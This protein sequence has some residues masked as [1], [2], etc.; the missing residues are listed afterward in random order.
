M[1]IQEGIVNRLKLSVL[2]SFLGCSLLPFGGPVESR[3][4][5]EVIG[6]LQSGLLGEESSSME[7]LRTVL[8]TP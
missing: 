1:R 4:S 6:I 8:K 3:A 7:V 5:C 2:A